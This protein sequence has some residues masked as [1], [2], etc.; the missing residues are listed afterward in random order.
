[1]VSNPESWQTL[2]PEQNA[3]AILYGR[4]NERRLQALEM[5]GSG[6][7][8]KIQS[9][10]ALFMPEHNELA[11]QTS[12]GSQ[13]LLENSK[14]K[15]T[16]PVP[17]QEFGG[18]A[19]KELGV[20]VGDPGDSRH[21]GVHIAG[22]HLST[23]GRAFQGLL[24][25]TTALHKL[26]SAPGSPSGSQSPEPEKRIAQSFPDTCEPQNAEHKQTPKGNDQPSVRH[27]EQQRD[28]DECCKNTQKLLEPVIF[29]EGSTLPSS[30]VVD[31]P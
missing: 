8:S 12:F 3:M 7:P 30:P 24:P 28:R 9:T 25:K 22:V 21:G 27:K 13:R 23:A 2:R 10:L 29:V 14:R 31:R 6:C 26:L 11:V 17:L 4:M 15:P 16:T 20:R 5:V 18:T 1:M 19:Q